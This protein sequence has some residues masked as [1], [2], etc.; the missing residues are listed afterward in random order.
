MLQWTNVWDAVGVVDLSTK[1]MPLLR[2]FVEYIGAYQ[3]TEFEYTA[4]PK[5]VVVEDTSLTTILRN[6]HRNIDLETFPLA[7]FR[8]NPEMRGGELF[9]SHSRVYGAGD[10]T[11]AG[12]PK[13]GW[14]LLFLRGCPTFHRLLGNFPESH[15][16]TLGTSG[17][18][19]WG[20]K[21][22]EEDKAGGGYRLSLIHI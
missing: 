22:K 17:I 8:R 20:G 13:E 10:K 9:V 4:V 18:Q 15:R 1:N 14:R 19:I 5:D 7:L 3:G 6:V 16:F 2:E 21:R 12:M 11:R